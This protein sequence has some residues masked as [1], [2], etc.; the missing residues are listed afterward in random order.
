MREPRDGIA[1]PASGRVLD[2]IVLAHAFLAG[3]GDNIPDC[4]QLVIPGEDSVFGPDLPAVERFLLHLY[5]HEPGEE[6]EQAIPGQDLFPEICGLEVARI[7]RVPCTSVVSLVEGEEVRGGTRQAGGHPGFVGI[8][9]EVHQGPFLELE[10]EIVRI[11]VPLVLLHRVLPG[12]AGEGIL[13]FHSHDR[14]AVHPE[15]HIER[16]VVAGRIPHLTG[17]GQPIGCIQPPGLGVQAACR[18]EIRYVEEFSE[19][20]ESM[21]EHAQAAFVRRIEGSCQILEEGQS[22]LFPMDPFEVFPFVRLGLADKI[23]EHSGIEC[24]FGIEIAGVSLQETSLGE[25]TLFDGGLEGGL[26]V[27]LNHQGHLRRDIGKFHS[28]SIGRVLLLQRRTSPHLPL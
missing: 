21:A 18:G 24:S 13:Q 3:F 8:D 11:P 2:E 28:T 14:D 23:Q 10:D 25:K 17:D 15:N 12:L 4:F 26:G 5:M 19:G 16:V 20:L 22:G 27:P 6:I 9:S 1:L 7:F